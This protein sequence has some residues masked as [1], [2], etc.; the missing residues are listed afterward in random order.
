MVDALLWLGW[1]MSTSKVMLDNA[2]D[3]RAFDIESCLLQER[4]VFLGT[5]VSS[6][7]SNLLVQQL[8]Y[9]ESQDKKK[10]IILY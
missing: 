1:I 8:L 6:E 4:K 3:V 9:L 10:P 5:E 2:K 7:S